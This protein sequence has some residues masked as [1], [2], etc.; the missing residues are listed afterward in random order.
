MF[1]YRHFRKKNQ[2]LFKIYH[3]KIFFQHLIQEIFSDFVNLIQESLVKRIDEH[4][5]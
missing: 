3:V 2:T 1:K 4:R 5:W